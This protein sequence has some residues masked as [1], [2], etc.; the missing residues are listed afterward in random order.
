MIEALLRE[1]RGELLASLTGSAG[2]EAGQAESLLPP[3]LGRIAEALAGGGVDL[4]ELL[5][6]GGAG[7]L[8]SKLDIGSI[9]SLAGLDEAT[10]R[11]GLASLVPVV[12][13]L[14]EDEAG[15]AKGLLSMLGGG[16]Q[17]GGLAGALG[18]IAGKLLDR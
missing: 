11:N 7:A 16:G 8:L 18:G 15:G 13:R 3:A 14:L 4:G 5:G 10:T 9:A 12:L 1:H 2:L 17:G 6:S